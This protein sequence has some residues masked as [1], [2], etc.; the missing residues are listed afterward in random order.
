MRTIFHLNALI[1][2]LDAASA[3]AAA[4]NALGQIGMEAPRFLT[5][6]TFRDLFGFPPNDLQ[7]AAMEVIRGPGVYVIEA[8]MGM[9]KTEAA[10][11][12]SYELLSSGQASGLYFA[13]PT[14]ATSNRIHER[15]AE[16]L[17]TNPSGCA[18][19]DSRWLLARG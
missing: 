2:L 13:L 4:D 7:R 1:A 19:F 9:G 18:A 16:F 17:G 3:R 5:G 10:L 6:Q 15:V 12:A 11:A 8:P 14:Q